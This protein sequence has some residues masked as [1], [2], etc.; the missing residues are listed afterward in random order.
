MRQFN[1]QS[2]INDIMTVPGGT[3]RIYLKNSGREIVIE[4]VIELQ[5]GEDFLSISGDGGHCVLDLRDLAACWYS[6]VPA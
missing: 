5:A 3:L 6:P 2:W 1:L 4:N